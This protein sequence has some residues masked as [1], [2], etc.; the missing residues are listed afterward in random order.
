MAQCQP[1]QVT[2]CYRRCV[3]SARA[4]PPQIYNSGKTNILLHVRTPNTSSI[5]GAAMTRFGFLAWRTVRKT[6]MR[7]LRYLQTYKAF[8]LFT[9]L[10]AKQHILQHQIPIQPSTANASQTSLRDKTVFEEQKKIIYLIHSSIGKAT[11]TFLVEC[12]LQ[13]IYTSP[14]FKLMTPVSSFL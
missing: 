9:N 11:R 14:Y 1:L 7:P 8:A 10:Q 3:P 2:H 6:Y 4:Y 5:L 13:S 12:Q